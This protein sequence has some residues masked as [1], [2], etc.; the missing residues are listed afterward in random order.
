MKIPI[1]GL[2]SGAWRFLL[3][4]R[5]LPWDHI[6]GALLALE[7]GAKVARLDGCAFRAHATDT[8]LLIA[9]NEALWEDARRRFPV[10]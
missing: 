9:P 6:P 8:G 3:Y 7:A 4:W 10:P 5:T 2:I 1:D